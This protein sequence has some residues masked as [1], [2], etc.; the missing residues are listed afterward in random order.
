M[1]S[2]SDET[3]GNGSSRHST[4]GHSADGHPA[5]SHRPGRHSSNRA[6]VAIEDR[7]RRELP[8]LADALAV[9]PDHES[10]PVSESTAG[11]YTASGIGPVDASNRVDVVTKRRR[12]WL[13]A[14]A[15]TLVL[16]L[17]GVTLWTTTGDDNDQLETV[18]R[19]DESTPEPDAVDDG[20]PDEVGIDADDDGSADRARI[21]VGFGRWEPMA[22]APIPPRSYAAAYWDGDEAVFWAGTNTDRNVAFTDGAAYDPAAD[23]WRTVP[24]PGWGHPG[25]SAA[26][27]GE[28][29]VVVAKGAATLVDL[30]SGESTEL[31][32]PDDGDGGDLVYAGAVAGDETVYLVGTRSTGDE[33]NGMVVVGYE[34]D[35]GRAWTV[36]EDPSFSTTG[37]P[38]AFPAVQ[39]VWTGEEVIV[40][41]VAGRGMAVDP[42][43]GE[44]RR[45]PTLRT[46]LAAVVDSRLV[47]TDRGPVAVAHV[48]DSG[49]SAVRLA[50]L[51]G[52]DWL[53]SHALLTIDDFDA[54]SAVGAGDWV[55]MVSSTE[56]PLVWHVPSARWDR[57]DEGP[58]VAAANLVWTG[59]RVVAWGGD[60]GDGSAKGSSMIWSPPPVRAAEGAGAEAAIRSDSGSAVFDLRFES[61]DRFRL[62][63]PPRF[64]GERFEVVRQPADG[65]PAVATSRSLRLTIEYEDCGDVTVS[66]NAMGSQVEQ[67]DD[68]VV[69]CRRRNPLMAT[70]DWLDRSGRSTGDDVELENFDLRPMAIGSTY[71]GALVETWPELADCPTCHPPAG[72]YLGDGDVVIT[73]N[74]PTTVE[75]VHPTDLETLWSFDPGGTSTTLHR[76]IDGVGVAVEAGDFL[77]VETWLGTVQ[78][79]I[80][81]DPGERSTMVSNSGDGR[82]GFGLL[83]TSFDLEGDDRPPLLRR[84]NQSTGRVAWTAE[85]AENTSW[86]RA[87]PVLIG[88]L[89]VAA[90]VVDDGDGSGGHLLAAYDVDSGERRW[91]TE[92]DDLPGGPARLSVDDGN[93]IVVETSSASTIVVD[94]ETGAISES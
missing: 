48:D 68:T 30:S 28:R 83:R 45:L 15:A 65:V 41:T 35:G 82:F 87:E 12:P 18:D 75:A 69:L 56:A 38:P 43:V 55:V 6:T 23:R 64:A 16:G 1:N 49:T 46:G 57:D 93:G 78:W 88:D 73:V 39:T 13:A 11:L 26:A 7:L 2:G 29:L 51:V 52:R 40:W 94:A 5:G 90:G 22:E 3:P 14:A 34:P 76:L 33:A 79:S 54:A 92:L 81:R 58:R 60:L 53:W 70:I 84:F 20:E 71:R 25:L 63:L 80:E 50:R 36:Y 77:S 72:P 42:A 91:S 21:P 59:D 47:M 89:V 4:G 74:G 10:G 37:D 31:P 19:S 44:G 32:K 86:H 9:V 27:V 24:S 61:G 67:R 8:L 17:G 66:P 85:L 62:S